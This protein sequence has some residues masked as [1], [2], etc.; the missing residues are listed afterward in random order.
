MRSS[1]SNHT[2]ARLFV[3]SLPL[4]PMFICVELGFLSTAFLILQSL[5]EKPTGDMFLPVQPLVLSFCHHSIHFGFLFLHRVWPIECPVM[6]ASLFNTL[7]ASA[8][9]HLS[10]S[11]VALPE[12]KAKRLDKCTHTH[13]HTHR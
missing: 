12:Q 3:P 10:T 11:R 5:R 4:S 2:N 9:Q 1:L 7:L 13:T 8:F 6:P